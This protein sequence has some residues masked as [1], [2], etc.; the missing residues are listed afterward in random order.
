MPNSIFTIVEYPIALVVAAIVVHLLS[1][2]LGERATR[3]YRGM[4]DPEG[5][6]GRAYGRAVKQSVLLATGIAGA[7][8][9]PA[10]L[11]GIAKIVA[12]S[13]GTP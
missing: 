13:A 9:L 12:A 6:Y 5:N 11:G 2:E 7:I 8:K 4:Y 10:I 1:K 3:N